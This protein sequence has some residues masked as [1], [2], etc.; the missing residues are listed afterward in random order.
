MRK[1]IPKH[2]RNGQLAPCVHSHLPLHLRYEKNN[3]YTS[4]APLEIRFHQSEALLQNVEGGK[5]VG[6]LLSSWLWATDIK[7]VGFFSKGNMSLLRRWIVYWTR[8]NLGIRLY[9][10]G[11]VVR[12]GITAN[13]VTSPFVP[14]G[15]TSNNLEHCNKNNVRVHADISQNIATASITAEICVSIFPRG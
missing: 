8:L 12:R 3:Y 5:D 15:Q 13:Q 1:G 14:L 4:L 2:D 10:Q 9:A 6:L 11:S 7:Y